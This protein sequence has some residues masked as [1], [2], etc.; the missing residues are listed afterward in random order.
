MYFEQKNFILVDYLLTMIKDIILYW[1]QEVRELDKNEDPTYK[2]MRTI[3][4]RVMIM[5]SMRE[6]DEYL[7]KEIGDERRDYLLTKI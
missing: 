2:E 3:K 1:E 7:S 5:L 6:Y 4:K